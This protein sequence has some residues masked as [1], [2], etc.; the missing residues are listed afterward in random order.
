M[1]SLVAEGHNHHSKRSPAGS[2]PRA[3]T[4]APWPRIGTSHTCGKLEILHRKKDAETMGTA[5]PGPL[6]G[7]LWMRALEI[8]P[9]PKQTYQ[10]KT[11]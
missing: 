10:E 1:L 6:G 8:Q 2:G 9:A 11:L 4:C 5:A 3:R 7:M